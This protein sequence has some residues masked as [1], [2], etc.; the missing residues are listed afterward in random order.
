MC[1]VYF[2]FFAHDGSGGTAH[3]I[4]EIRCRFVGGRAAAAFLFGWYSV[5]CCLQIH[6][7]RLARDA[8]ALFIFINFARFVSLLSFVCVFFHSLFCFVFS[9]PLLCFALPCFLPCFLSCLFHFLSFLVRCFPCLVLSFFAFLFIYIYI[10]IITNIYFVC[11]HTRA[12]THTRT[13]EDRSKKNKAQKRGRP[14]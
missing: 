2:A 13:R 11:V 3:G 12:R 8:A 6:A 9:F 5:F 4:M 7:Q 14:K 10:I 1:I